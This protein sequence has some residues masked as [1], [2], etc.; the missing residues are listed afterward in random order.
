MKTS[1]IMVII[2][3]RIAFAII[4]LLAAIN[5]QTWWS[6]FMGV[7]IMILIAGTSIKVKD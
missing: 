1:V 4:G 6:V 7:M 5:N 2:L 3:E